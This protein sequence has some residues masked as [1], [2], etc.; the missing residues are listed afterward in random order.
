MIACVGISVDPLML[1][2]GCQCLCRLLCLFWLLLLLVLSRPL[3][4]LK[5]KK[6]VENL[7]SVIKLAKYELIQNKDQ[8]V[9]KMG[10]LAENAGHTS[11][12][13]YKLAYLYDHDYG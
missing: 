10:L 12:S 7:C 8:I 11:M 1:W 9:S 5:Q 13:H 3:L 4:N 6:V 2:L